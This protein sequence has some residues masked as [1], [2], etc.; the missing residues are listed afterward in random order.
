MEMMQEMAFSVI[1][2]L[3][4]SLIEAFLIL[5]SHLASK[6]VLKEEATSTYSNF[7]KCRTKSRSVKKLVH[8]NQYKICKQLQKNI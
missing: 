4:F 7:K 5:P 2:A 1:A 6:A 8:K 3:L